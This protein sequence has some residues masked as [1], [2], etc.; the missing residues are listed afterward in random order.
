MVHNQGDLD[1]RLQQLRR[2][3]PNEIIGCQG[4]RRAC[5]LCS[6][7]QSAILH[8]GRPLSTGGSCLCDATALATIVDMLNPQPTAG[9]DTEWQT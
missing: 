2:V 7:L 1:A 3:Y 6:A 9:K 8:R 4:V 5:T